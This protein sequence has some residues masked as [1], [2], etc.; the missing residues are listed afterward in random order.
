VSPDT[1]SL[2]EPRSPADAAIAGMRDLETAVA[3]TTHQCAALAADVQATVS[4]AIADLNKAV[5]SAETRL[6]AAAQRAVELIERAC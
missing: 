6:E 5:A 3:L 4:Q 2:F 1:R